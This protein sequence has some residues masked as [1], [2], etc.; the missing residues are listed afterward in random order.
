MSRTVY[1][2]M[3]GRSSEKL[4]A[5]LADIQQGHVLVIDA[6]HSGHV[7]SS[8]LQPQL[9]ADTMLQHETK[10]EYGMFQ[11]LSDSSVLNINGLSLS[12]YTLPTNRPN[13]TLLPTSS[14]APLLLEK[15]SVCTMN[16]RRFL[17]VL[18]QLLDRDAKG[19]THILLDT[20]PTLDLLTQ[21]AIVAST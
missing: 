14:Y 9:V 21:L 7:T 15:Q 20:S 11:L 5:D 1:L 18:Q 19:F 3:G 8:L 17:T 10:P 4:L 6:S 12:T 13:V 16:H 2:D